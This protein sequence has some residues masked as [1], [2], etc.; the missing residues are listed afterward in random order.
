MCS[1]RHLIL[2]Y[3]GRSTRVRVV[4]LRG[5]VVAPDGDIYASFKCFNTARV[6]IN[7]VKVKL[8]EFIEP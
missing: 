3:Q 7:R 6:L 5:G 2:D 4:G 8:L 1:V